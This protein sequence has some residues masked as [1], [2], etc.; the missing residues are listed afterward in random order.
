[1]K[2]EEYQSNDE[3]MK[4][5]MKKAEKTISNTQKV[6]TEKREESSRKLKELGV[7]GYLEVKLNKYGNI[8]FAGGIVGVINQH[9]IRVQLGIWG[10]PSYI[11]VDDDKLLTEEISESFIK[12]Y[13]NVLALYSQEEFAAAADASKSHHN[14]DYYVSF[15][16]KPIIE[17][18]EILKDLGL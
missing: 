4:N 16:D 8:D 12:K 2:I 7:E 13:S 18:D 5:E 1:M 15:R 3:E 17:D 10:T 11:M 14:I 9:K 6:L